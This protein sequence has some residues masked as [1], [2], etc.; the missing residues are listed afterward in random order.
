MSLN[1]WDVFHWRFTTECDCL[2]TWP[3]WVFSESSFG[4]VEYA[5]ALNIGNERADFILLAM[6]RLQA[7]FI[8]K[9]EEFSKLKR[10][11]RTF[12]VTNV[13]NS[14][15]I[16]RLCLTIEIRLLNY[17]CQPK[18]VL[19]SSSPVRDVLVNLNLVSKRFSMRFLTK[20]VSS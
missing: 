11:S 15:F 14:V 12:N 8:I 3:V 1:I 18:N 9:I 13:K 17:A 16:W 5:L 2:C 10:N 20:T 4:S 6:N 7:I 19:D